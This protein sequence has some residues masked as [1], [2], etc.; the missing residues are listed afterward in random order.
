[1][2]WYKKWATIVMIISLLLTLVPAVQ[3]EE[4][5]PPTP[6]EEQVLPGQPSEN[7]ATN[8]D[9]EVSDPEV[10]PEDLAPVQGVEGVIPAVYGLQSDIHN[11]A[12]GLNYEWSEAPEAAYPDDSNKLTDGI[13]GELKMSDPAWVGHVKKKTREVVFDLGEPKS[14]S[15]IKARFMQ[16]WPTNS[17]LVPLTVSMYVSDD[18]ENWGTLSHNATQLLWGDGPPREEVYEWDGATDGIRSGNLD[19]S[20]AYAR[21]V[22]VTFSMH[23]RAWSFI[24]EIEIMGADGKLEGAVTVPTEQPGFLEPG[25]A[26]AGIHNLNLLYNGH[27]PND[28]GTWKK[29]RIIPNISYVDQSGEPV[30]W[31]FDGVLYLGLTSPNGLAFD[32]GFSPS[33]GATLKEW[34]W[35]LD[36]TF[37]EAGDM[38][39]LNEATKEVGAKLDRPDFKEKVV[40]MIPDPGEYVRDFGVIDGEPLNFNI[41]DVGEEKA[42]SNREKAIQWWL[43]QVEERWG[44][45]NYSNLEL[46]GMYWLAEQIST[47]ERGPDLLQST[48][49]KVHDK[50]LK[51]FWIPH[52][53]AYKSYMWKDVGFDAVAFQPNYFFEEM[54]YDRLEDAANIA[55]QYGM[56]NELEF[57]DRM[58]TDAVFRERFIDYL[59]SG[60]ET[61]LMQ[62]GFKAYYQGNNAIF[63]TAVSTD[64]STRILYEWLYQFVN[65][66]YEK[67]NAAPP[68]AVVQMNGQ[69]LQSGAVIPDTEPVQFTWELENDDGS[70]L[71]KVTA[72]FDGK[73]YTEGTVIDLAGKPGKHE[74]I[75]T[76][77]AGKSMKTTYV[78]EASTNADGLKT[79]VNRF[80]EKQQ[81]TN[82][83]AAR[84]LNNYLEMMK[85]YEAA[86]AAKA[87]KY[88]K[89]FN[90]KLDLLKKDHIISD[91]AY[92]TLKEGVYYLIGNEAANKAVEASSIE[93]ANP[94]YAPAKAVDG[95]A[96]TRWASDYINNSWFQIDLGE[97]K[98]MDT[99]RIDWEYA[100]AKTYR[101]LVSDDKQNWTNAVSDND[102]IITAHDGKETVQFD[103][104]KARYIKFQGIER[105]TD[106]GYSFYEFGVYN[107]SGAEEIK[108]IEG[109]K[110]AVDAASKKVTID[111]LIMNGGLEKV[112]L[113]VLN[114]KGKVD[115]EGQTTSTE[116]GG[117]QFAFTLKTGIEGTYEAYLS[118]D[119]MSVPEKVTFEYKKANPGEGN[120]GGN[121][122]GGGS[123]GNGGGNSGGSSGGGTPSPTPD[124]FQPQPDGSVKTVL[125]SK[126][127][128]DGKTAIGVLSEQEV[129]K[130]LAQAK[131]DLAGKQKLSIEIKK[132]GEA[133]KYAL[134][135]PATFL[136]EYPN[137]LIEVITPKASIVLS[138]QMLAKT[139]ELGKQLRFVIGDKDGKTI[140]PEAQ[141]QIG[142]RPIIHLE[143]KLDGKLIQW[144]N[145]KAPI[146]VTVPYLVAGKEIGTRIGIL[147]I[148]DQGAASAMKGAIYSAS[149]K[150]IRFQTDRTGTYAVYYDQ[151]VSQF[152][153]LGN[154][155]WAKEA[156]D[157]LTALG[158][159]KGTSADIFS[160]GEQVSRADFILML[161]RALDLK[162]EASKPFTDVKPQDYYYD[163]VSIAKQLD[164][165]T[166][167]DGE[168]LDP[169]A[170]ITRQDMMVMAVRALKAAKATEIA[171]DL[172]ALDGF[173]DAK[174]ISA[175]AAGSI[176][177]MIEQGLIQG[178]GHMIHPRN[179]TTRAETAVFLYRLLNYV[180]E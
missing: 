23:T 118:T 140:S 173:K 9:E 130:A 21:Y 91:S 150:L 4:G 7:D 46:V 155:L 70:G 159:V 128:S 105:A 68:E 62:K 156:I 153:D 5:N 82:A 117:F 76:V 157:Q 1:M 26:T 141:A 36:K 103:P 161:V 160:P 116:A 15:N 180:T 137:L 108:A 50:N 99:V 166:G 135:L 123:G 75:I 110:A 129:R 126:L 165:V 146:T 125:S 57:D 16:D 124:G 42:L 41:S 40:L 145:E 81:F 52:F 38:Q 79:L 11:L 122:G 67:N 112:Q 134:D 8:P 177:G 92:S 100:R 144:K 78:I 54:G 170:K 133:A 168:R 138:G 2:T 178:D 162:A 139:E 30:D 72:T 18:K 102:G 131:A 93:G 89:G 24:D 148:N 179:N 142:N 95:F 58:L 152:T 48:S 101:L 90:A 51:F 59:N 44:A 163:A 35:Y 19:A 12:L 80:E 66:T 61:G 47:S 27:Y 45:A 60:V 121:N 98:E 113:K 174:S 74:L 53:L 132:N 107:L 25:E 172:T 56:S 88:L 158:I 14:I 34:Q 171:G 154:H 87:V 69:T 85:R 6:T 96:A 29:E 175:Y 17:M 3:A 32:G 64:P 176:A 149:D 43:D 55:K 13:H 97:V 94:N 164:I 127:D 71:T 86:D 104:L 147:S 31:L 39:Q 111:G 49:V 20:M 22:K 106:Y 28:L 169:K 10:Q 109:L 33:T 65:G 63:N 167:V 119:D 37:A 151:P 120:G 143:A 73:P 83:E 115:Y 136:S 114:L 84:S 77:A